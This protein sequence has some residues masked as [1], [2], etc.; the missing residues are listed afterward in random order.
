MKLQYHFL[1]DFISS[2]FLQG[3]GTISFLLL[4]K[5]KCDG[6]DREH[7]KRTSEMTAWKNDNGEKKAVKKHKIWDK[8]IEER[9]ENGK[10]GG[11]RGFAT[12]SR[13]LWCN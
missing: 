3:R 9:G 6:K 10:E 7:V 13:V 8:P 4:R 2:I 12:I 5:E 11:K 1:C